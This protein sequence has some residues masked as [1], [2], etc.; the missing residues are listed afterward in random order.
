VLLVAGACCDL[1]G[2]QTAA[3]RLASG[4]KPGEVDVVIHGLVAFVP[5]GATKGEGMKS[6]FLSPMAEEH[7]PF[8]AIPS[9]VV[10]KT[11]T[12]A[13]DH[14]A[15]SA[16]GDGLALWRFTELKLD[17][18]VVDS[19]LEYNSD[20]L[21]TDEQNFDKLRW[22]PFLDDITG[23]Y[24]PHDPNEVTKAAATADW[25]HGT[26]TAVFDTEPHTTELWT[27]G[28]RKGRAIADGVRIR[29]ALKDPQQ[30]AVLRI[31][32]NATWEDI[33][34]N[35]G[36]TIQISDYPKIIPKPPTTPMDDF[37]HF[38]HFYQLRT[39]TKNGPPPK[40]ASGTT[41]PNPVRCAPIIFP[42]P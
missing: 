8:V 38:H 35:G 27:I 34:V 33:P 18:N 14:L 10:Y 24:E 11:N 17:G 42:V 25:K 7:V 37:P 22:V 26:L 39:V 13:P 36:T 19:A 2:P 6:V 31:L 20:K 21:D 12:S 9:G 32:R 40:P 3:N 5:L 4:P 41:T 28:E 15:S 1:R 16:D 23:A 29:L 30:P